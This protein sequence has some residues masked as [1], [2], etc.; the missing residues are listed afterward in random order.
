MPAYSLDV[1]R[2]TI[3]VFFSHQFEVLDEYHAYLG[4]LTLELKEGYKVSLFIME[5]RRPCELATSHISQKDFTSIAF[6][7]VF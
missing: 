7:I 4:E 2:F 6:F 1:E 5:R 3:I